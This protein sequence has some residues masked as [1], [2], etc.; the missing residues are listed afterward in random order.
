MCASQNK[1]IKFYGK[2]EAPPNTGYFIK[3]EWDFDGS[4]TFP[5]SEELNGTESK[6][7]ATTSHKYGETGIYFVTFRVI[8]DRNGDKEDIIHHIINQ[9]RVRIVVT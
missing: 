8:L 1:K 2:A 7:K 9:S 3:L 5:Y 4:G 6:I